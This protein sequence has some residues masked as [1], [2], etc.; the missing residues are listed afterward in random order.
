M[1][2]WGWTLIH[3]NSSE[4]QS[5]LKNIDASSAEIAITIIFQRSQR[6]NCRTCVGHFLSI[7]RKNTENNINAINWWYLG[8][9]PHR[10]ERHV[11]KRAK[12]V[13]GEKKRKE[14]RA[15]L[16]TLLCQACTTKHA[17]RCVTRDNLCFCVQ[18]VLVGW[19]CVGTISLQVASSDGENHA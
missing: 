7:G 6:N 1:N 17:R 16:G 3:R 15:A 2:E 12:R 10:G 13:S 19:D 11:R 18:P 9:A 8:G 14:R 5:A 4:F